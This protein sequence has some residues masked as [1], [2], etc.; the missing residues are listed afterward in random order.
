[1]LLWSGEHSL[2]YTACTR[3]IERLAISG[4]SLDDEGDSF[5]EIMELHPKSVLWQAR[6]GLGGFS[7]ARVAAAKLEV[8]KLV[9]EFVD[10]DGG[11]GVLKEQPRVST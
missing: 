4:I 7:A 3:A 1:M 5:R 2:P 6:L 11:G 9:R 10:T 8:E